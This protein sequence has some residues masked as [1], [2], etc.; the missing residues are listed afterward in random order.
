MVAAKSERQVQLDQLRRNVSQNII[1][2]LLVKQGATVPVGC[3][4]TGTRAAAAWGSTIFKRN[5][6]VETLLHAYSLI[7]A[8]R[9]YLL[10]LDGQHPIDVAPITR[11]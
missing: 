6:S 4:T 10:F 1:R 5:T 3:A 2:Y 7:V 9:W 8:A 11:G